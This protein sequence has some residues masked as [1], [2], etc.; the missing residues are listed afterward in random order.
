M[1][2]QEAEKNFY[3]DDLVNELDKFQQTSRLIGA[4]LVVSDERLCVWQ[5]LRL[6]STTDRLLY[7]SLN[8]S[9]FLA[10]ALRTNPAV[11]GCP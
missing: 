4:K 5:G 8:G 1:N 2:L 3:F 7:D 9:L 6:N 11:A 10:A